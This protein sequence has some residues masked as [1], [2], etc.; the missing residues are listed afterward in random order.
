MWFKGVGVKRFDCNALFGLLPPK[1]IVSWLKQ[2]KTV[3]L[4]SLQLI[5]WLLQDKNPEAW[6]SVRWTFLHLIIFCLGEQRWVVHQCCYFL[7]FL[8]RKSSSGRPE[9][10][11]QLLTISWWSVSTMGL[12]RK[13]AESKILYIQFPHFQAVW[14]LQ[15]SSRFSYDSGLLG[16]QSSRVAGKILKSP[17]PQK[18]NLVRNA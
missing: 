5:Q 6:A 10:R 7:Q 17:C 3:N 1:L 11:S 18:T 16:I 4:M 8:S 2:V 9:G 15:G 14:N 13:L 12:R